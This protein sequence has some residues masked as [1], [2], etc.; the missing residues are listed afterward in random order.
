VKAE[1]PSG[2]VTF[3]FTDVQGSTK[4]LHEL[5]DGY[6]AVLPRRRAGWQQSLNN[7]VA[8]IEVPDVH[9]ARSG[10]VAIA[11]QTFGHGPHDIVF[12][13][14]TLAELL[15][16]WEQPLWVRHIEGLAACGRVIMFDKRGTGLSDRVR[17]VPTLEARMDDVRAVLDDLGA[18]RVVLW[19]AHE[20]SRLAILFAATYPERTRALVLY[21]PTVH[22]VRT[23]DYPWAKSEDEWLRELQEAEKGWGERAYL[24]DRLRRTSP[25]AADDPAFQDWFVRYARRSASPGAA[26]AF[27]RMEMRSDV[28]DVLGSVS[29][30]TLIGYGPRERDEA[31]YVANAIPHA[32]RIEIAGLGDVFSWAN[33]AANDVLLAETKRFLDRLGAPVAPDRVL[34]TVLFTDIV[35][36]TE[37]ASDFGDRRWHEVLSRHEALVRRELARCGGREVKTL[38]DGFMAAFEGPARAIQ[39]AVAISR[40]VEQLGISVRQGL[41][42][43]ECEL[44]GHDVRGMAV[45]IAHRVSA[46]ADPSEVLVSSTVKDLVAG[47]GIAFEDRGGHELKGVPGEWRLFA[48]VR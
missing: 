38:G 19:T 23:D 36:S 47:S 34:A 3:L 5:G 40:G 17:D 14:G 30:P 44:A 15:T 39:S 28:R 46:L 37:K 20:G 10:N 8:V 21:N 32:E 9:Y 12:I 25:T 41:H 45:N 4:L 2:V 33:P 29:A 42:T 35:G 24:V 18:E 31:L 1:L 27:L 43:G 7:D 13:R 6:A 26:A 16:A 48:V 22:G 11:Y